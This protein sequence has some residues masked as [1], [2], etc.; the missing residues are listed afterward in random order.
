MDNAYSIP[1][2]NQTIIA[3]GELITLRAATAYASRASLLEVLRMSI[4]QRGT[5][6]SQQLGMR[7]GLKAS[8][9]GTFTSVTPTPLRLGGTA[10]AIVGSTS[11]AASSCG[12]DASANGAGAFTAAGVDAFNNLNGFLWVATPDDRIIIGPDLSFVLQ[13]QGTPTTLT[14]WG[15]Y[16][17][18]R[19]RN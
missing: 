2:D 16:L 17:V 15:G 12:V 1:L 11:N 5:S 13:L 19:E 9:F 10:S 8:A 7:W 3:D 4:S 6:T 18:F 14:G